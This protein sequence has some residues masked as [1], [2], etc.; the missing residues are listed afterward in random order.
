LRFQP[1][2]VVL[3]GCSSALGLAARLFL[4]LRETYF[5]GFSKDN[6]DLKARKREADLFFFLALFFLAGGEGALLK[7]GGLVLR[8]GVYSQLLI[9]MLHFFKV[10]CTRYYI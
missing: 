6:S 7:L 4:S 10:L 8:P 1:F 2:F 9:Y 5:F 3:K